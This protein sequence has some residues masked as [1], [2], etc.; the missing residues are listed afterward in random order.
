M[1]AI[2]AVVLAAWCLSANAGSYP[3]RTVWFGETCGRYLGG[4]T[5]GAGFFFGVIS[6]MNASCSGPDRLAGLDGEGVK[7]WVAR[8]CAAHPL[9]TLFF[10]A[11]VMMRERGSCE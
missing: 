3:Q 4:G 2:G 7:A 11:A 1:G 5:D 6:G 10:A 9:D 8:Y